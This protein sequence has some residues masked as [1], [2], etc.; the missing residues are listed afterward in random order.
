M[1]EPTPLNLSASYVPG[2]WEAKWLGTFV[3]RP[4]AGNEPSWFVRWVTRWALGMQWRKVEN[5]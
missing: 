4:P 3:V 5:G 2:K 1:S